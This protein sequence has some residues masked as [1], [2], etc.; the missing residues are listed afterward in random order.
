M[1]LTVYEVSPTRSDRVIWALRELGVAY[2]SRSDR[3]LFGSDELKAVHPQ[4]K[5]PAI[6]D[7]DRPL[8]ES[9]AI[10]TWLADSHADKGLGFA[11][12]TWERALHDQWTAFILSELEA[13]LWIRARNTFIYEEKDRLEAVFVQA[14]M[15]AGKALAVLETHLSDKDY[16]IDGRFS[17]TDIITGF[18]TIWAQS[19]GLTGTFPK[20]EAYNARLMSR[21]HCPLT[22]E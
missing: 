10:C 20:V 21:P 1:T 2:E 11:S 14:D 22:K 8:F 15:E 18:A 6:M 16:M 7:D 12:G 3:S 13:H 5:L 19:T 4:G 9:A 17:V